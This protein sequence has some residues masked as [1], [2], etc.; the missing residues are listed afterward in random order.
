MLA[1]FPLIERYHVEQFID[2]FAPG[3]Y[4]RVM[5]ARDLTSNQSIAF[6]VMRPEHL[7]MD[8]D[9]KWEYRAFSNEAHLLRALEASPHVIKL[10]DC[11]YVETIAEAPDSGMIA[12]F[13]T[14]AASF[15][16]A[17]A[18]YAKEGWRPYLALEELSRYDNLF[19]LM[20]PGKHNSRRRLP[21]EEG[22]TLALQFAN[23]LRLAHSQKIVY[24]DHK[25]EH[26]Y[27]DGKTLRIID[28]NSSQ[29][30]MGGAGEQAE[31]AKDIHNL[32]VGVLYPI[33]TGMSPQKTTLRPQPGTLEE[34]AERYTDITEL[35]FMM[36]PTLS[37]ALQEL[38]QRGAQMQFTTLEQFISALEAVASQNGRDF[39]QHTS[40]PSARLARDHVRKG[41][42]ALRTGTN[43]LRDARDHLHDALTVEDLPPDIE[44]E[45]R[46]LIKA[47]NDQLNKRL[48]P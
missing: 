3:H 23:V 42:S 11:G 16:A 48:I 31:Y 13:G 40:T 37:P 44:D 9:M 29:Q 28:F 14:D 34:V 30:L 2:T 36:E 12:S 39:P 27:W 33:F 20:R 45:V 21:T 35:D 47:L 25:L 8:G 10:R 26:V 22:L 4:A 24:L 17:A 19:Y 6:K 38:L 7:L 1:S 46:R 43:A 5:S 15:K 41:L 18:E 32:C